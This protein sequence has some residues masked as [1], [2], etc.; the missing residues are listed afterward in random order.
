MPKKS[1]IFHCTES[2]SNKFW[3]YEISGNEVTVTWGRVGGTSDTKTYNFSS[4]YEVSDFVDSKIKEKMKK[5]YKETNQTAI[6][7]EAQTAKALGIQNKIARILW[8]DRKDTRLTQISSYDPNRWIYV[9][10]MNSW[11]KEMTR[12]LLSKKESMVLDT[13]TESGQNITFGEASPIITG[14]TRMLVNGKYRDVADMVNFVKV[15]R[16]LLKKLA[17]QVADVLKTV[18]FGAVGARK[19]FDDEPDV[20]DANAKSIYEAVDTSMMDIQV[21]TKF[22]GLGARVL[23]L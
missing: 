6:K 9:E 22:I 3:Q 10:V 12:L 4:E 11:S 1:A 20:N 15:V 18:K 7:E 19:L 13:I 21:A 2:K 17:Q 23:D 8:V 16:D 5:K 14:A